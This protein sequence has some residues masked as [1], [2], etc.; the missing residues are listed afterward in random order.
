MNGQR[1]FALSHA[2]TISFNKDTSAFLRVMRLLKHF[3]SFL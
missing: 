2:L 3:T 1:T